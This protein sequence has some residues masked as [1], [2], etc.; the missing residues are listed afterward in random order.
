MVPPHVS[1]RFDCNAA[2]PSG[3]RR[4]LARE[5]SDRHLQDCCKLVRVANWFARTAKK[6]D[7]CLQTTSFL[8]TCPDYPPAAFDVRSGIAHPRVSSAEYTRLQLFRSCTRHRSAGMR[9]LVVKRT[10]PLS[11]QIMWRVLAQ[12]A[13]APQSFQP[14]GEW[15]Q[16]ER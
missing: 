12:V 15:H 2:L 14:D 3:A 7:E 13:P 11:H 1:P 6:N 5:A 10:R 8:Q 16:T 4:V 9:A